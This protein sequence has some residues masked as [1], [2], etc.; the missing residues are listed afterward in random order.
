MCWKSDS[1]RGVPES[2]PF[3]RSGDNIPLTMPLSME[4][5]TATHARPQR[6]SARNKRW[7]SHEIPISRRRRRRWM[8]PSQPCD[9]G[10]VKTFDSELPI[11]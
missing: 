4:T 1:A 7:W 3:R 5:T 11:R 8:K 2:C 6:S 10:D 9:C